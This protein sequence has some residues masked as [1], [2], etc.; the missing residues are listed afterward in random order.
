VTRPADPIQPPFLIHATAVSLAGKGL[1]IL[2]ASGRGK[3]AL[4]LRLIGMGARLVADDQVLIAAGPRG[5]VARAAVGLE[6][7]I[8][9]RHVG[10]LRLP[11]DDSTVLDLIVDLDRT[12]TER[13]PPRRTRDLAGFALEVVFGSQFDFLAPAL[14]CYLKGER[15]G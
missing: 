1:L 9:A 5:L 8:E 7:L 6:G 2:G 13:L 11:A 3:S 4:A 15:Q 14:I 12:E 10:I